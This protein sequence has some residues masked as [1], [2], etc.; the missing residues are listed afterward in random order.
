MNFYI[1]GTS[2]SGKTTLAQWLSQNLGIRHIEL[3]AHQFSSNW[4]KRTDEEFHHRVLN[5]IAL[6]PF[7]LC[8][9]YRDIQALV[10]DKIDCYIWLDY[11]FPLT[12]WR[13]VK[14]TFSRLLTQE[15]CCGDNYETWRKQ[16]CDH[17]SIFLW[18]L[19]T[20]RKN[21]ERYLLASLAP[22][23][24]PPVIRLCSPAELRRFQELIMTN[25][26]FLR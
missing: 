1:V 7:V 14:R 20:F 12:F 9:N 5:E 26:G 3:D 8:G 23:F 13:V 19:Q 15:K 18:V 10:R 6:G 2:G 22:P 25:P 11:S 21:R 24:K 4:I 16:F 17:S